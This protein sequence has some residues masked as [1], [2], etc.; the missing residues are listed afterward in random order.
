MVSRVST[1]MED[2]LGSEN[3]TVHYPLQS[4]LS[5]VF[6]GA[7]PRDGDAAVHD[8][9]DEEDD[10]YD[11]CVVITSAENIF[12]PLAAANNNNSSG[13]LTRNPS[14]QSLR[15]ANFDMLVCPF[16]HS[17]C[18]A[19]MIYIAHKLYYVQSKYGTAESDRSH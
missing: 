1:V 4:N 15:I 12:H 5:E 2:I 14:N 13:N 17:Y 10:L 3:I 11:D 9:D 19:V 16:I 6:P 8:D 18:F 7:H